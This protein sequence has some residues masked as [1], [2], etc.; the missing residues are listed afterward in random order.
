MR[1]WPDTYTDSQRTQPV[2]SE[3]GSYTVNHRALTLEH[4]PQ[5]SAEQPHR[6]LLPPS[7]RKGLPLCS[8]WGRLYPLPTTSMWR[9]AP[10]V[11]HSSRYTEHDGSIPILSTATNR[12]LH[13]EPETG[14]QGNLPR[15]RTSPRKQNFLACASAQAGKRETGSQRILFKGICWHVQPRRK[16]AVPPSTDTPPTKQHRVFYDQS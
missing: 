15:K 10:C 14:I 8:A 9:A 5:P 11:F 16:L 6:G 7:T 4:T 1:L 3:P 2:D 13:R 12:K